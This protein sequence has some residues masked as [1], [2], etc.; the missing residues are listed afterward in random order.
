MH[1]VAFDIKNLVIRVGIENELF[2]LNDRGFIIPASKIV[3]KD[4]I[5]DIIQRNID[6]DLLQGLIYGIQ[7]EPHPAQLEIVTQPL[8]YRTVERAIRLARRYI[9]SV[10]RRRRLKIY[11]GSIHP[12]QSN[13]FPINGTHISISI[14]PKGKK[15][16]PRKFLTYVHNNIRNHLPELIALTANSPLI[17][18]EHSGY[19]SSRL[20]FSRVLKPS[21]YAVIKRSKTTIIPREKRALLKYAFTFTDKKKYEHK[22]VVN[23][24]GL[25]FLDLTPRGPYTNIIEDRWA[26][27]KV[28]RL[29]VRFLDNPSTT[30]YIVDITYILLG[31]AL[32]A[33]DKLYRGEKLGE[34]PHLNENRMLAIKYGIEASF[35]H[36]GHKIS[37]SRSVRE[38]LDRIHQFLDILDVKLRTS[39][40]DGIPEITFYGPPKIITDS[41][42]M[43]RNVRSGRVLMKMEVHSDRELITM[44]GER[45]RLP[46]GSRVF[47][48]VFP[49]YT[50]EWQEDEENIVSRFTK[51]HISYWMLT[52]QGYVRFLP[53]DKILLATSPIGR[54]VRLFSFIQKSL[55]KSCLETS[56]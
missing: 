20:V 26:S 2:T 17:A 23:D 41:H 7:W 31:L 1:I 13:P 39:L 44:S 10:A 55:F 9:A 33:I 27:F 16:M 38:M 43:L 48:L 42:E 49:E 19:M 35:L 28:S 52:Q 40:A 6:I 22:V 4:I 21:N 37:A 56:T 18:G 45:I 36:D 53:G 25:R 3:I 11:S 12:I 47:G 15:G 54:L 8:D 5:Q 46:K 30:D 50:F 29:E 14:R 34:R 32:E 24:V 51:I